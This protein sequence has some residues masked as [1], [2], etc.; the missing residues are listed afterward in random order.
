MPNWLRFSSHGEAAARCSDA[1]ARTL[2]RYKKL[3]YVNNEC[4][5]ISRDKH[6][7]VYLKL[8]QFRQRFRDK[9]ARMRHERNISASKQFFTDPYTERKKNLSRL[10]P[11][12]ISISSLLHNFSPTTP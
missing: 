5:A 10:R 7:R 3:R 2:H 8:M 9:S 6:S 12:K 11:V 1:T 4:E